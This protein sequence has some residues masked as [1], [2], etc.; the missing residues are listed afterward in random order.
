MD[1]HLI[2]LIGHIITA[3][4][5]LVILFYSLQRRK[6][7]IRTTQNANGLFITFIL[8]GIF[9][10]GNNFYRF[11]FE[12][13]KYD[14]TSFSIVMDQFGQYSG[15]LAQGVLVLVLFTNKIVIAPT[16]RP[17]RILII[18][19]H[20]DDIEL[21][22]GAS[23]AKMHD[24]GYQITG[25]VMTTGEKGGNPEKRPNEAREGA[26]FLGLDTVQIFNFTDTHLTNDTVNMTVEI[27]KM[28][29]S[30]QPH[31]IFTHSIHDLHQDH[32]AVY[33]ASMRAVRN[34]RTTVLSYE[35]PSVT[36]DFRP[37]YYIDVGNY[38]DVKIEAI[39]QHWDQRNK[40]YMKADLIR[41]KLAFRG[42][43]AKIDF[44]EGFEVC[45]MV[46]AI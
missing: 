2:S 27:E 24:A 32:Q 40:P 41:G 33:E 28:I 16:I 9:L 6:D 39:R 1:S 8:I 14:E 46:S 3:I 11:I 4:S 25:M 12:L 29:A 7:L 26:H 44:A 30:L 36:Q 17:G 34:Y 20:P 37:N 15:I 5:Y 45:R 21:A 22:A 43:Q 38:V 18:G 42:S 19:A 10:A 35:S 31:I 13:F 23:M